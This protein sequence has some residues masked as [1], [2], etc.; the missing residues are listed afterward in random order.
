M[1]S[2]TRC[3]TNSAIQAAVQFVI[4]PEVGLDILE[5]LLQLLAR[6]RRC[7]G[8]RVADVFLYSGR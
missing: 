2:W 7:I 3:S 8:Y 1:R 4:E 6:Y 5:N